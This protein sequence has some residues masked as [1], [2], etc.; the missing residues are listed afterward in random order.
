MCDFVVTHTFGARHD[1]AHRGLVMHF[2]IKKSVGRASSNYNYLPILVYD[3][4]KLHQH[5]P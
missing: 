1:R 5:F 4:L 3:E 2:T